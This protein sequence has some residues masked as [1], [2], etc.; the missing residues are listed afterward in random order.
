MGEKKNLVILL[1]SIVVVGIL[2]S[3]I[4]TASSRITN[5]KMTADSMELTLGEEDKQA[6]VG[7]ASFQTGASKVDLK[8]FK[9]VSEDPSIARIKGKEIQ[10]HMVYFEVE[11]VS[12]G[13]TTVYL[14]TSQG[15]KSNEMRVNVT[16]TDTYKFQRFEEGPLYRL[17]DYIKE[18]GYTA[19]YI[20]E[21]SGRDITDLVAQ[22]EWSE[23]SRWV[24][25]SVESASDTGKTAKFRIDTRANQENKSDQK[26]MNKAL[27]K[28][29]PYI[30]AFKVVAA[31]GERN[32]PGFKL[33]Y[34]VGQQTVE[35]VND[36][37]WH[38]VAS[39]TVTEN[40][41]KVRKI[42]DSRVSGTASDPIILNFV[43]YE[44]AEQNPLAKIEG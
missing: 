2:V 6:V 22:M 13:M 19:T 24:G 38:L 8:Q 1:V 20:D 9:F 34:L 43:I 23:L 41:K 33:H 42:C 39:C 26:E 29:F 15:E 10:N 35:A 17:Q 11:A 7:T 5:L 3:M 32:Y 30:S 16:E 28:K 40:G 12:P 21:E 14:E 37:T 25:V 36:H 27:E 18:L 4:G 31:Y 44:P